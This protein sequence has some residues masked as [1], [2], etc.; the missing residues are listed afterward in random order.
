MSFKPFLQLAA[1]KK[2]GTAIRCNSLYKPFY[3][4]SYLAA[5][6]NS[7]LMD[8][9]R[10]ERVAFERLAG[11]FISD[12]KTEEALIAWLQ[13][14]CR[15][16][17]LSK[18]D[19]GYS[20]KGLAKKLARREND[21]TLALAQEV[22]SL[23]YDLITKTLTKLR[24]GELWD[25]DNQDA[26]LTT[27]SSRVLEPFQ[28]QALD[29]FI[30]KSGPCHL[31]EVGCG[32]GIYIR[33]AAITNPDFTAVGLELQKD[34]ANVALENIREW[35]LQDRVKVEIGDIRTRPAASDFD[36][37]TLYN[38]IYYFPIEERVDLLVKIRKQL[39]PDGALLLT[40]CCQ[41]G[42]LG[43]EVLNVWGASNRHGGRLPSV[44]EMIEQMKQAGFQ[45]ID[46]QRLIPG[47]S[48][49]AFHAKR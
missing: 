41:N 42:N 43:M 23:H 39:K 18:N 1:E 29:R 5:L 21:P 25:L 11:D 35:G 13:L 2:L 38:N 46:T 14:G 30:P 27:R 33:H 12:S 31:L 19:L 20:L 28:V 22:S 47:D 9:L 40:T 8:R 34:A 24:T 3:K 15:L 6:K 26:E 44:Q 4:L 37:V 48:F 10:G 17:L 32:S 36:M 7:G 49:Y 45:G 16:G